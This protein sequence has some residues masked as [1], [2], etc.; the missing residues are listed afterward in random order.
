MV[1]FKKHKKALKLEFGY[2]NSRRVVKSFDNETLRLATDN[3]VR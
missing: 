3:N 2:S 1:K